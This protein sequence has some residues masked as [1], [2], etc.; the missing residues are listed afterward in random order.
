VVVAPDGAQALE[1]LEQQSFDLVLMDAQMPVM[2]GFE[3]TAAIRRLEEHTRAHIPIIA[4]TAHAMV[5][6]RHRCLEAGMDGYIAKPVHA[7]ELFETIDSV[8][9]RAE[10]S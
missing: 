5:G 7:H 9:A 4:M 6:D 2:D 10:H 3:C 8:L 1:T